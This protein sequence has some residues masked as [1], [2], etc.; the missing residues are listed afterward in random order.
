MAIGATGQAVAAKAAT[1]TIPIVFVIGTDPVELGLVASLSRPGGNMTGFTVLGRALN[2]KRLE[3]LSEL[4]PR[5]RVIAILINQTN[6]GAPTS[7]E[8]LAPE[9]REVA[10]AGLQLLLLKAASADEIDAVFTAINRSTRYSSPPIPFLA[11]A[12]SN[13]S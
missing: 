12:G 2:A 5:A 9:A 4:V 7:V 3:L 10:R 8:A 13:S 1:S 11:K 6:G